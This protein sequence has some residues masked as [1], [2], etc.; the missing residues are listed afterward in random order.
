MRMSIGIETETTQIYWCSACYLGNR[1][2]QGDSCKHCTGRM[3]TAVITTIEP[4]I[5]NEEERK[6]PTGEWT[7]E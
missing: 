4:I 5:V 3:E 6:S 7:D 2:D 1:R